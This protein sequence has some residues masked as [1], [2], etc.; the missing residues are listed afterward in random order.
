[1]ALKYLSSDAIFSHEDIIS[2][3]VRSPF[4]EADCNCISEIFDQ[5]GAAGDFI[6]I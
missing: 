1:M 5:H 6:A 3:G 2:W 4:S